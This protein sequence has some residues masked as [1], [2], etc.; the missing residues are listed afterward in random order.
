M[1][2][3]EVSQ[4]Q[5]EAI[6]GG[7]PSHFKAPENPVETVSSE[8]ASAF[9]QKLS[10]RTG[11]KVRL[12]NEAEWE[13]ACR[14]GSD[15]HFCFGNDQSVL[16]DYA[17]FQNNS[18]SRTH[19]VGQKKPNVWG[20][21]D[22]HGNVAEWC[23]DWQPYP[24]REDGMMVISSGLVMMRGGNWQ[25]GAWLCGCAVPGKASPNIRESTLGFRIAVDAR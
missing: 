24:V 5:Y 23:A 14:A 4:G 11:K 16:S 21:H 9:C 2:V 17:W 10:Q 3:T 12:P 6:M 8:D 15:G 25:F 7:N 13:Y 22:M 20:L 1:A 19:P 18:E